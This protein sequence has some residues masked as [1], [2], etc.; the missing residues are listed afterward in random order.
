MAVMVLKGRLGHKEQLEHKGQLE[1]KELK[2][3]A[4]E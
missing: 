3:K 2:E 4:V 1:H